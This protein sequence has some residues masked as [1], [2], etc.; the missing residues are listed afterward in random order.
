[1]EFNKTASKFSATKNIFTQ[2]A[3]YISIMFSKIADTFL[4]YE[5]WEWVFKNG[6]TTKTI[7]GVIIETPNNTCPY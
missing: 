6:F 2:K 7:A 5:R 1:M 4:S 3:E